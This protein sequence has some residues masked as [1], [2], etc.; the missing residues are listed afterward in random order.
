M[1]TRSLLPV[2]VLAVRPQP[3]HRVPGDH[4][5][6]DGGPAGPETRPGCCPA[7]GAPHHPHAALPQVLQRPLPCHLQELLAA[8]GLPC[9]V[10]GLTCLIFGV[11][12]AF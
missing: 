2:Q 4:A 3:V 8:G 12:T 9:R 7:H 1:L 11:A 10:T 5:A 6:H